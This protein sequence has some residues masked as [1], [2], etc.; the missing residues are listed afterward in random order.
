MR[1]AKKK[2]KQNSFFWEADMHILFNK[3]N[4]QWLKERYILRSKSVYVYLD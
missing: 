1:H 2:K 4:V 3:H